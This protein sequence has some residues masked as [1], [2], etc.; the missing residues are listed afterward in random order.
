[1]V[2]P[3]ALT[4]SPII[5]SPARHS[6]AVLLP[7]VAGRRAAFTLRLDTCKH[8]GTAFPLCHGELRSTAMDRT[9]SASCVC[10]VSM[11]MSAQCCTMSDTEDCQTRSMRRTLSLLGRL[12]AKP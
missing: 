3:Y 1:M 5:P 2:L 12:R 9:A 7:S 10:P 4:S 8:N 11:P 6:L